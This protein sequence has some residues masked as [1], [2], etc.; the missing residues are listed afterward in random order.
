MSVIV[1]TSDPAVVVAQ[2]SPAITAVVPVSAAPFDYNSLANR[3]IP[4]VAAGDVIQLDGN[5]K[6]P[7]IDGSQL[8][9]L[10]AL[11]FNCG[12]FSYTNVSTCTFGAFRGQLIM[13]NGLLQKIPAAGI[14]FSNAGLSASTLYY[15]YVFMNNGVMT[16]EFSTTA[17][18]TSATAG[19][20]GTEIKSGD[21]TRTLVGMIYTSGSSQFVNTLSQRL[22]ASWFN[23]V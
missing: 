19:N 5:A 8:L 10:P 2:D 15:A 11:G 7:A 22:V 18:A 12:R 1:V 17:H 4:G 23:R 6:L 16:G 14:S 13:I 9:N 20:V 3:L 21:D